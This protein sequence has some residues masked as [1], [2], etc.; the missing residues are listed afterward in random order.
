MPQAIG[1]MGLCHNYSILQLQ[2]Y[3]AIGT[4]LVNTEGCVPPP[5]HFYL[6]K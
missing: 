1:L 6:Q 5:L 4:T 3:T 2:L